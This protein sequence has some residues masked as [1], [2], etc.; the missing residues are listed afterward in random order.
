MLRKNITYHLV[1]GI[2]CSEKT[3]QGYQNEAFTLPV[4]FV[5]AELK[6]NAKI[7]KNILKHAPFKYLNLLI[8]NTLIYL[9]PDP[10]PAGF[11]K[12]CLLTVPYGCVN[13]T[14]T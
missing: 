2:N 5:S 3:L 8:T 9:Y 13:C 7:E 12:A 14:A 6:I 4:F 10:L 1:R 11:Y